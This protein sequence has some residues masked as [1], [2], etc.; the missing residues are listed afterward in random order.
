MTATQIQRWGVSYD[1][2]VA[3]LKA[4]EAVAEGDKRL[5]HDMLRH[6]SNKDKGHN[7][8]CMPDTGG[9]NGTG[10]AWRGAVEDMRYASLSIAAVQTGKQA[11]TLIS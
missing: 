5:A 7:G 6:A 3:E 10:N 11:P 2:L 8:C 9:L 4:H 1:A